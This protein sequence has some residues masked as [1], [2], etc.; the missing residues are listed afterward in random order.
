MWNAIYV[1]ST[2]NIGDLTSSPVDYFEFP[3]FYRVAAGYFGEACDVML[4]GGGGICWPGFGNYFDKLLPAETPVIAWGIGKNTHGQSRSDYPRWLHRCEM[5]GVRDWNEVFQWVPCASCMSPEF[6]KPR[7]I[8]HKFVIYDHVQRRLPISI[9][10]TPAMNNVTPRTIGEALD[11]LGSG[12]YVFTNSYH[13]VYWATLLGRKVV[14]HAWSSRFFYMRHPPAF[15]M[16]PSRP[17][18][19]KD[20]ISSTTTYPTALEE[21][22]EANKAYYAEV[23]RWASNRGLWF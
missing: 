4:I 13:G 18:N 15:I 2:K 17:G 10:H 3:D 16:D 11:F 22:R 14:A 9:D 12:E 21:C 5:V 7:E 6:D 19:W 20:I 8:K 23:A 1:R